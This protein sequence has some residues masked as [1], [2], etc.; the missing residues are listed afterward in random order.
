M[1]L[2]RVVLAMLLLLLALWPA[3]QAPIVADDLVIFTRWATESPSVA[4]PWFFTDQGGLFQGPRVLPT[5]KLLNGAWLESIF[6]IGPWLGLRP[7]SLFRL[8]RFF[9]PLIAIAAGA[10]ALSTWRISSLWGRSTH[11]Q[12]HR[13]TSRLDDW[14]YWF[15]ALAVVAAATVQIHGLWSNDPVVAYTYTAWGS[16]AFMFGYIALLRPGFSAPRW[17]GALAVG[18][19]A[20]MGTV[21][22]WFYELGVGA[23]V[24]ALMA[25][26]VG[27]VVVLLRPRQSTPYSQSALQFASRGAAMTLIPLAAFAV[28]RFFGAATLVGHPGYEGTRPQWGEDVLSSLVAN[29]ASNFP[30]AG[31]QQTWRAIG[32]FWGTAQLSLFAVLASIA[33]GA[34]SWALLRQTPGSTSTNRTEDADRADRSP[35]DAWLPAI[36]ILTIAL[37]LVFSTTIQAITEK[38]QNEA[39]GRLGFVYLF[40]APGFIAAS[41]LVA[42]VLIIMIQ[43]RSRWPGVIAVAALVVFSTQQLAA[44]RALSDTLKSQYVV[45]ERV[46]DALYMRGDAAHDARCSALNDFLRHGYPTYYSYAIAFNISVAHRQLYRERLCRSNDGP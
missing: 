20:G 45:N 29:I 31:L 19:A 40:Y 11:T 18:A 33:L 16:A 2:A 24:A 17:R 14:S 10:F 21:S 4:F 26:I 43:L 34:A 37:T 27:T 44:N 13:S 41:S 30:G 23:V 1:P 32:P 42:I 35:P 15:L 39:G 28:P 12:V 5:S 46:L 6:S 22:V 8:W 7:D 36:G 25:S 3:V 9:G 38:I